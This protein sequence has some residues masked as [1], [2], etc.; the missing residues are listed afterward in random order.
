[1]QKR[2]ANE[3][4]SIFPDLRNDRLVSIP[5]RHRPTDPADF[6]VD[7]RMADLIQ[8]P[9]REHR[10]NKWPPSY[11]RYGYLPS[12]QTTTHDFVLAQWA[13]EGWAWMH[14]E[15]TIGIFKFNQE[16]M[17]F[18]VLSP[19]P[20]EDGLALRFG[21]ASMVA[22]DPSSLRQIQPGQTI[23]LGVT[24]YATVKGDYQQAY[25]AFRDFLDENGCRFSK[26]YN[27]PVHWNE[28]YDNPEWNLSTPGNPPGPRLTRP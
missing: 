18:S 9:G 20:D 24:R 17:E 28:L 1:M 3:V 10:A 26:G 11:P 8:R 25:Y 12:L 15:Y 16:A 19:E 6:D 22:S 27:P 13:S 14:G 23:E 4:G 21:G 7:F 5:F 2:I